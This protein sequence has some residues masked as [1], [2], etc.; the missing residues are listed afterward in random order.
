M[1]RDE[2]LLH[3]P[4]WLMASTHTHFETKIPQDKLKLFPEMYSKS[5]LERG[6]RD[7]AEFR[8][9][10]PLIRPQ[11]KN[12]GKA[13]FEINLLIQSTMRDSD[14]HVPQ[15]DI[16]LVLP[17]FTAIPIYKYGNGPD[18]DQSQIGCAKITRQGRTTEITVAQFGEIDPQLKLFQATVEAAYILDLNYN[19]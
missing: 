13:Y 2:L 8:F 4:R 17:A 3:L 6:L 18:D 14:F 19:S 10:G 9:D 16:G 12:H 15:V 7:F 1:T 11:T 5:A